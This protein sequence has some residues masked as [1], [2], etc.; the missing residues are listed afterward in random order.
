MLI[1]VRMQ[2]TKLEW[3]YQEQPEAH[4]H[5]LPVT[6]RGAS[7]YLNLSEERQM[8]PTG[9]RHD[10]AQWKVKVKT[11]VATKFSKMM[12]AKIIFKLKRWAPKFCNLESQQ[13]WLNLRWYKSRQI[14]LTHF[15][16][17]DKHRINTLFSQYLCNRQ[18]VSIAGTFGT[19]TLSG[20]RSNNISLWD[21]N[22]PSITIA[23]L[24]SR[25]RDT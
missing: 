15:S 11:L 2:K 1:L 14:Y 9:A 18:D 21:R 16:Q 12:S 22:R 19:K 20:T 25:K 10:M 3:T 13:F 17:F 24:I 7:A 6:D 5:R 8:L 4:A 23:W